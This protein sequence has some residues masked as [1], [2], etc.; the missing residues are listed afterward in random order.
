MHPALA[1]YIKEVKVV[2]DGTFATH[3]RI[4]MV[5]QFDGSKIIT[6]ASGKI[7]PLHES[8]PDKD[9]TAKQWRSKVRTSIEKELHTQEHNMVTHNVTENIDALTATW[10]GIMEQGLIQAAQDDGG[11]LRLPRGRG[12][13]S[14]KWQS[15][16]PAMPK[17]TVAVACRGPEEAERMKE[18]AELGKTPMQ[19][20]A[21]Y[22]QLH[23]ALRSVIKTKGQMHAHIK[24]NAQEF[25]QGVYD[26]H[27]SQLNS[28]HYEEF[29]AGRCTKDHYLVKTKVDLQDLLATREKQKSVHRRAARTEANKAFADQHKGLRRAFAAA[30]PP[31]Q[32]PMICIRHKDKPCFDPDSIDVAYDEQIGSIFEGKKA[33]TADALPER[34]PSLTSMRTLYMLGINSQSSP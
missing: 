10:T 25:L 15:T 31:P 29:K 24:T 23:H 27:S 5:F 28:Q 1:R 22:R 9:L 20:Q 16:Q 12:T 30:R 33:V 19:T 34:G 4:E 3:A 2:D 14:I 13:S 11:T 17:D 7:N 8:C 6:R 21:A 26:V 32:P 18:V